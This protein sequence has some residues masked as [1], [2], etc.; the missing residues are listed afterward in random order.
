MAT[1]NLYAS[2]V[3]AEH[4]LA[5]WSLDDPIYF[6]SLLSLSQLDP[7][8]WII[9]N[10]SAEFLNEYFT[11]LNL[12]VKTSPSAVIRGSQSGSISYS[13]IHSASIQYSELDTT[14]DSISISAYVWEYGSLINGYEIGFLYSNGNKD[15]IITNSLGNGPWQK[16]Q[17]TSTIPNEEVSIMPFIKINYISGGSSL[18]YDVMINSIA[19]GQWSEQHLNYSQGSIPQEL[20]GEFFQ[21]YIP[22]SGYKVLQLDPY[23]FDDSDIGYVFIDQNKLL[24]TNSG[25]SMLYG[26]DNITEIHAPITDNLPSIAL[27]GKGFLNESGKYL[28]Q[29]FEF[30]IRINPIKL[31][32]KRIMGPISSKD[33]LYI[34]K[35]FLTLKVGQYNKS[36]FIG[37]WYRPMLIDIRYTQR[38]ISLLINGDPVISIDIDV[39]N[40]ELPSFTLDWIG[41]YGDE[42]LSPYEIDCVAIYPYSVSEQIAKKRFIYAQGVLPSNSVSENFGGKSMAIDFPFANYSATINYPDMNPWNAGSF[43]NLNANSKFLGFKQFIKPELKLT[44]EAESFIASVDI[45]DWS[46]FQ[47]RTWLEWLNYTWQGTQAPRD[48]NIFVDNFFIQESGS[49]AFFK[50]RPN[51]GYSDVS[52]S[53]EFE[54]IGLISDKVSSIYGLFECEELPESPQMLVHIYN[55]TNN[56]YFDITIDSEG[57]KYIYNGEVLHEDSYNLNDPFFVGFNIDR[58]VKYKQ[59]IVKNFFSNTQNLSISLLNTENN[60]FLGK[61]YYLTFENTFYTIKN[62]ES[63][64]SQDGFINSITTEEDFD[65]VGS[66]TFKALKDDSSFVLDICSSGY[67]EDSIPLSYFGK[68]ITTEYGTKY[69]DL[70]M[71]QFNIE[72]PSSVLT[73][74]SSSA[75]YFI[76]ENIQT[77]ITLQDKFS[78]GKVP[79]SQYSN[80]EFL[81]NTRVL[82]FDNTEDVIETKFEVTDGTIIFP[83]KELVNFEDYYITIHIEIKSERVNDRSVSLKKMSIASVCK[84]EK[85]LFFINTSS[86]ESIYPISKYDNVYLYKDKNPFRIYK[87]STPYLYLT[88]DSGVSLLPYDTE[89]ERGF[90]ILFNSNRSN[91]Y[92]AAGFQFWG[93]YNKDSLILETKKIGRFISESKIYDFYL[94]P[95]DGGKRGVIKSFDGIT[96]LATDLVNVVNDPIVFY[97]NGERI[98][99]PIITPMKWT[100]IVVAFGEEI[101]FTSAVGQLEFYEGFL[102]NNFATFQKTSFLFSQDI[103]A[104]LW[105]EVRNYQAIVDGEIVTL[106]HEWVDWT[107]FE[108]EGVYSPT[109]VRSPIVS[110]LDGKRLTSSYLGT[111]SI[112][113]NDPSSIIISYEGVDVI[114]DVIWDTSFAKPV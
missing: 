107:P 32:Q 67:W 4:P 8:N 63:K 114:S 11:P 40:I 57:I 111:S 45:R 52:I 56:S 58:V 92:T 20:S 49:P 105:Q 26:S 75:Q 21:F 29:T 44:G 6:K 41:F 84:D 24:A 90:S 82:D 59:D 102:Y 78:V 110:N 16:I 60:Q 89:L 18:D 3:F 108:W 50:V 39:D 80:T 93:M 87:E 109:S 74:P 47:L 37:K 113:I 98:K 12:P 51:E 43:N 30:W 83:P 96:G 106:D 38:V 5:L 34:D 94:E 95:I 86:G 28:E 35:E 10:D 68:L 77:Y 103:Q 25:M 13:Q 46:E 7:Q 65:I 112:T 42:N 36:Y 97:Q 100:S 27:P 55:S 53:I 91:S 14:K 54:K 69:Y 64:L 101:E 9:E 62:I 61:F 17:Y 85:E 48:A 1:S 2:R 88:G 73:N 19:V 99:Y 79:Y 31:T 23:G 15:S 81:S 22:D 33:G 70:D 104:R 72:Y 76:N 71:I 66:Y